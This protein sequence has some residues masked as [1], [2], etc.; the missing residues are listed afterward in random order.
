MKKILCLILIACMTISFVGCSNYSSTS[1]TSH[2]TIKASKDEISVG[3]VVNVQVIFKKVEGVKSYAIRP[4]F[5]ETS[6]ELVNA[7]NLKSGEISDSTNGIITTLFAEAKTLDDTVVAE[8]TLRAK[9]SGEQSA[10]GFS[11]SL[12]GVDDVVIE[13]SQ[14]NN[15]YINVK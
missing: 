15:I 13:A 2:F 3:D 7:R 4:V 6:F 14:P 10:I 1:S 11:I 12:K 8:Y 5:D 9:S